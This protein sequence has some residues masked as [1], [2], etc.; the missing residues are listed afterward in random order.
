MF[1][2]GLFQT[3][4]FFQGPAGGK[5]MMVWAGSRTAPSGVSTGIGGVR[6]YSADLS[7]DKSPRLVGVYDA[8]AGLGPLHLV[9]YKGTRLSL[10]DQAG[11]TTVFDLSTLSFR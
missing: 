3:T 4:N 9:G 7:T 5:W 10:A 11:H 8:P 1:A 6:V 2:E